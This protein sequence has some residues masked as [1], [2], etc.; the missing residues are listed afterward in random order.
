MKEVAPLRTQPPPPAPCTR[1]LPPFL[2]LREGSGIRGEP[3]VTPWVWASALLRLRALY[4]P[5]SPWETSRAGVSLRCHCP[6]GPPRLL[7][8]GAPFLP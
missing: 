7:S 5:F 6:G 4:S 3:Q 8:H 2:F 1:A